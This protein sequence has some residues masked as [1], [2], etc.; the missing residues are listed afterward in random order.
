MSRHP[1]NVQDCN[2]PKRTMI[3]PST[4]ESLTSPH[5]KLHACRSNDA[6]FNPHLVLCQNVAISG[7]RYCAYHPKC[8]IASCFKVRQ[9][10]DDRYG[11]FYCEFHTCL[12]HGCRVAA[13]GY[14]RRCENHKLCTSK[15]CNS[16][17]VR[18]DD[19]KGWLPVCAA[20]VLKRCHMH[21]CKLGAKHDSRFCE[22]HKC[23]LSACGQAKAGGGNYCDS[24]TCGL[25]ACTLPIAHPNKVSDAR[26]TRGCFYCQVHECSD[27]DCHAPATHSHGYCT[28]HG[29]VLARC[30]QPRSRESRAGAYCISHYEE[31]LRNSA[32]QMGRQKEHAAELARQRKADEE[33]REREREAKINKQ[34]KDEWDKLVAERNA[35]VNAA[36][37]A[38]KKAD[39]LARKEMKRAREATERHHWRKMQ[40]TKAASARS[41]S[42]IDHPPPSTPDSRYNVPIHKDGHRTTPSPKS[43][44][45]HDHERDHIYDASSEGWVSSGYTW[46]SEVD[47]V[48]DDDDDEP[49]P[50]HSGRVPA[51][52]HVNMKFPSQNHHQQS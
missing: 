16:F 37:A 2:L 5:C 41:E 11:L 18:S 17:C 48:F 40:R 13:T 27:K 43:P 38:K 12:Q 19:G 23:I 46:G 25:P 21:G 20:H 6:R 3:S 33:K 9:R 39:D 50:D 45:W 47:S 15:G 29:C 1:C 28:E 24:H 8:H 22:F 35:A 30:N 26:K 7:S 32:E 31:S 51:F 10:K 49:E 52:R 14:D 44:R 36:K 34:K 42:I 4:G